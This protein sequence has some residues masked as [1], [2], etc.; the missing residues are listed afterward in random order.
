MDYKK[1]QKTIRELRKDCFDR[2]LNLIIVGSVAY[3][4]I[5]KNSNYDDLDCIIIY[6]NISELEGIRYL[7]NKFYKT[8]KKLYKD[9]SV[10]FCA[11]KVVIN[12]VN[13]SL[14]FVNIDYIKELSYSGFYEE[15]KFF[16]KFT[17]AE[18]NPINDYY[19]FLGNKYIYK[20]IKEKKE[21]FNIYYLPKYLKI[22][23][24]F[25]SGVLHNKFL[26]NPKF[27][28]IFDKEIIKLHKS[29][30]EN[31]RDFYLLNTSLNPQFNIINS[32]RN[33]NNFSNESKSFIQNLFV[34]KKE[35]DYEK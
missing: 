21:D 28:I 32:I 35:L 11:T 29:I 8:F 3:K 15:A 33:W 19:D 5:N 23:D 9:N 16:K 30:L 17:N 25:Y 34:S 31:Y 12:D 13:L 18:E 14:D 24:S 27:E 1:I 20:K 6:N 22:N 2:G 10:D 4:G 7:D 26:H